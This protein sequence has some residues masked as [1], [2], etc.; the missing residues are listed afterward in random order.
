MHVIALIYHVLETIGLSD[1][2][3][4]PIT[5]L[6]IGLTAGAFL[7]ELISLSFNRTGAGR[8][9]RYCT[10]MALVFL[11]VAAAFGYMDWQYFY[12]GGWLRP[13]KFKLALAAVFFILLLWAVV[14]GRRSER[15]SIGSVVVGGLCLIAALGLG[16]FGGQLVYPGR[17][18]PAPRAFQAGETVFRGNCSGCHPYGT[19]IIDPGHPL[20]GAA[21]LRDP[22][23]LL[24]WIRNPLLPNG[25]R[26]V[27]PPFS[28]SRVTDVEA[29]ALYR[30]ADAA[31]KTAHEETKEAIAVPRVPVR[32]DSASI[33]RGRLLFEE[34]CVRCHT[35]DSRETKVG[36]GLRG[37]LKGERLPVSGRPAVPDNVFRQLRRPYRDMPSFADSLSDEDVFN[38]I[39]FLNTR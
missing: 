11:F 20:R 23:A 34:S 9:A 14:L 39:A 19:N 7:L 25:K 31:M 5:H 17:T 1:P 15:S 28:P 22:A 37:I 32:T 24:A 27:M 6:P 12:G 29:R 2:I 38:L 36:P 21:E 16:Y 4:P 26:G 10:A 33:A 18:P 8:A 35:A 30:Y 3:H 13:V